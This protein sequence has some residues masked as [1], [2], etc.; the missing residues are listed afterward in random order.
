VLDRH[1]IQSANH[2]R[3]VTFIGF[4]SAHKKKINQIDIKLNDLKKKTGQNYSTYFCPAVCCLITLDEQSKLERPF[5]GRIKYLKKKATRMI[6]PGWGVLRIP[7]DGHRRKRLA[8]LLYSLKKEK[9]ACLV[10]SG[11]RR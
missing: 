4:R 8:I 10:P 11:G 2:Q 1:P 6:P 5:F 9:C 3:R 7:H